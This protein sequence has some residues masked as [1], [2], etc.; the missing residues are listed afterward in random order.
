M[1]ID[2]SRKSVVVG[3]ALRKGGDVGDGCVLSAEEQATFRGI[4]TL[5]QDMLK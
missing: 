3:L 4:M 5:L 1:A 2:A